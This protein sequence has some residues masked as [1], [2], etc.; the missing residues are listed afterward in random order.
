[1][2]GCIVQAPMV[3]QDRHFKPDGLGYVCNTFALGNP[4]ELNLH[5]LQNMVELSSLI[6]ARLGVLLGLGASVST[7]NLFSLFPSVFPPTL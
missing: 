5:T 1:M 2:E 4:I 7:R 3:E 6:N